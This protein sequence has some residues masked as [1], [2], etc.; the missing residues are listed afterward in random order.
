M[1]FWRQ[2]IVESRVFIHSEN[3]CILT[4]IFKLF[5]FKVIMDLVGSIPT[6][7]IIVFHSL[8]LFFIFFPSSFADLPGSEYYI[9]SHFIYSIS[10]SYFFSTFLVVALEFA[11]SIFKLNK[12]YFQI[13]LCHSTCSNGIL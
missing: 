12:I 6:V 10:I 3:I 5:A 7:F 4:A 11:I 1:C 9:S 13:T 8:H 2:H